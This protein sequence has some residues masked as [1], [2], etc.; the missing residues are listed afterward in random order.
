MASVQASPGFDSSSRPFGELVKSQSFRLGDGGRVEIDLED[1]D[2]VLET[3]SG[4]TL[5][6]RVYV[7]ASD[8]DRAK[9][10]EGLAVL[11]RLFDRNEPP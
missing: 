1:A 8:E 2:V 11:E 3:I 4:P 7:D 9:V 6:L 5:K 10:D